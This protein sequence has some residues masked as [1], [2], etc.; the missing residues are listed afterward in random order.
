MMTTKVFTANTIQ[1][2]ETIVNAWLSENPGVEIQFVGQSESDASAH[3]W[4]ITFTILYKK[5]G[6]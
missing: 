6:S 3:G 1:E 5:I 4:S 2:L